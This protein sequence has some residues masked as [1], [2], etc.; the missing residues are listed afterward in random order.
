MRGRKDPLRG[1]TCGVT[2]KSWQPRRP[3]PAEPNPDT[4]GDALTVDPESVDQQQ[5]QGH[6]RPI[7]QEQGAAGGEQKQ[8]AARRLPAAERDRLRPARRAGLPGHDG[9]D[10]RE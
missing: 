10:S 3:P 2:C 8:R 4:A 5:G 1:V 7:E 6:A 9:R